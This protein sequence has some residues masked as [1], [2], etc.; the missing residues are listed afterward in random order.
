MPAENMNRQ[1]GAEHR[2]NAPWKT[3]RSGVSVFYFIFRSAI[4]KTGLPARKIQ[5]PLFFLMAVPRL[6]E[7]S[8][9]TLVRLGLVLKGTFTSTILQIYLTAGCSH[10]ANPWLRKP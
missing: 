7:L 6:L 8:H 5:P 10:K 4:S 3:L 1:S 2:A 9:P